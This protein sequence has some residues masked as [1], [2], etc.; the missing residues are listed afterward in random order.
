MKPIP[1]NY[2]LSRDILGKILSETRQLNTDELNLRPVKTEG[3]VVTL[4]QLM[5]YAAK[6]KFVTCCVKG[7]KEIDADVY[8]LGDFDKCAQCNK[9][10][11]YG[12]TYQLYS[13]HDVSG[14]CPA[15]QPQTCEACREV[16]IYE[17]R[18]CRH[19]CDDA[20]FI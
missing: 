17:D 20:A 6:T 3:D 4:E 15:H 10:L 13:R 1:V 2:S 18:I 12:H 8:G 9:Y 14:Y 5:L 16:L 7:C 19:I 11:C